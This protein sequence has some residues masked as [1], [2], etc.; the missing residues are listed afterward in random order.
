MLEKTNTLTG[1]FRRYLGNKK[2]NN[3]SNKCSKSFINCQ[4]FTKKAINNFM[5]ETKKL[6]ELTLEELIKKKNQLKG[7]VTGLSIV[8]CIACLVLLW[9]SVNSVNAVNYA[10]ITVFIGCSV[11]FLP[12]ITGLSK[13]DSEIKSRNKI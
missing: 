9:L 13:L 10:L 1:I 8:M 7:A 4:Y 6:P 3:E 2:R 5:K 11:S 12:M